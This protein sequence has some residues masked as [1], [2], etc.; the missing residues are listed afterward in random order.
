MGNALPL[1]WRPGVTRVDVVEVRFTYCA[2]RFRAVRTDTTPDKFAEPPRYTYTQ[3]DGGLVKACGSCRDWSDMLRQI[4]AEFHPS[5]THART[6]AE[7]ERK[8]FK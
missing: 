8:L 2:Q 1:R 6:R 4:D 3:L 7:E 5:N